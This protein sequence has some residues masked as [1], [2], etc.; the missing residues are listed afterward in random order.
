MAKSEQKM[1]RSLASLALAMPL[2][3]LASTDALAGPREQAA[4]LFNRINTVPPSAATIDAMAAK[5]TAGDTR[6][7]AMDAI[8]DP[9]GMFYNLTLKDVVSRW[10]SKEG[11][12]R[13]DLNDYTA[14]VIGM[15]RD[16]VPFN[17]VLSADLV[18]IADSS[19]VQGVPNYSLGNNAHHLFLDKSAANLKEV[20]VQAKQSAVSNVLPPD[21]TA[22]VMT[23]RGFA[24]SFINAG[25]NRA[26]AAFT[27]ATFLCS[28]MN[29]LADTTRPDFH[30][31][32]DVTR[33]P[34]GDSAVFRNK[35]AGCHAGMD[36]L[37][38]AF[39]YYDVMEGK[40]PDLNALTYTPGVVVTKMN[41][42]AD[43][44]PDGYVTTDDSWTNNWLVGQNAVIGWKGAATGNG[45]KAFGAMLTAT[46]AFP[47]CMAKRA[48][49]A[50]CLHQPT[51]K[52]ELAG[53]TKIAANFAKGLQSKKCL[54][55]CGCGLHDP[56]I[57]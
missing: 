53:V 8:N 23:T 16:E 38:G 37:A 27:F 13:V 36:A 20:L 10:T 35:C 9:A 2:I 32:R 49:T 51:T 21:A 43:Q 28:D 22:G 18:Y 19:K 48:I 52:N 15:V 26:A 6:G 44:F 41:H 14:T 56:L 54:C 3:L 33:V 4:M 55:R 40:T 39:A 34:G 17:T 25:T 29:K 24:D 11:S 30:V 12:P 42:N 5:I 50:M 45:A 47:T 57:T 46:D 7:A 1:S 31:R